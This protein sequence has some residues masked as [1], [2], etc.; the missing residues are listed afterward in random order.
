MKTR[1]TVTAATVVIAMAIGLLGPAA[2]AGSALT[3]TG[4]S[5]TSGPVGTAV[6]I[7]G[8]GFVAK[9]IVRFNGTTAVVS[10]V[11]PAATV[12]TTS[13][14]YAATTGIITVTDPTTG[15]TVG[16]PNSPFTVTR[17]IFPSPRNVWRGGQLTLFGSALSPDRSDPIGIGTLTVGQ[18]TTDRFGNF[19]IG[20][21][22]PW[23]L[24]TGQL[25]IWVLDPI[26]SKIISVIFVLG[27]W[28]QY[29]HDN[30]HTGLDTFETSLS[31]T[32]V[33]KLKQ[34]WALPA[35][36]TEVFTMIPSVANGLVYEGDN[37]SGI[38]DLWSFTTAGKSPKGMGYMYPGL[39]G[40][41]PAVANAFLY[42]VT[43][44]SVG[45]HL[46]AMKVAGSAVWSR[47]IGTVGGTEYSAPVVAGT[48][49]YVGSLN[50]NLYA[51]NAST[52]APVWTF[53]AGGAIHSSPA[54]SG[55]IVYVGSQNGTLWAINA[56]TGKK[57]WSVVGG[58][59][60]ESSPAVVGGTVY[61]GFDNSAVGAYNAS[62]GAKVWL[63]TFS[64]ATVFR[65][66][67]AVAGGVVYI[68]G[69]TASSGT[70]YALTASSGTTKWVQT[71]GSG[72]TDPAVANGVV[73]CAS[74][75]GNLVRAM[76]ASTGVVLWHTTSVTAP[77]APII[78]NG[79]VF[80]EGGNVIFAFSL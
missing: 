68:G 78:S 31:T 45:A 77:L 17:G 25:Q 27:D 61:V 76:N 70:L 74:T 16:L 6:T 35:G 46:S 22:V 75:T 19:Q 72:I 21:S 8:T 80:L 58:G 20:V 65:T 57:V 41:E 55:G 56:T 18:V 9:D 1:A 39:M 5:P 53:A 12:L 23:S 7:T 29:R 47:S 40:P 32:S 66:S 10:G 59:A 37:Q 51:F 63:D 54:V 73:Y 14:P 38:G 71:V 69:N 26:Y 11:N 64:F 79:L 15:Q 13:V 49:V 36:G 44:D 50:G 28:P 34:L 62:T 43:Y 24:T 67:P 2:H 3:M 30:A 60:V 42:V 33:A 52:G 4:F 48:S